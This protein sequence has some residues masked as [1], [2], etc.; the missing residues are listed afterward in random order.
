MRSTTGRANT[1]GHNGH[2]RVRGHNARRRQRTLAAARRHRP[3]ANERSKQRHRRRGN[4][5]RPHPALSATNRSS[6]CNGPARRTRIAV[7]T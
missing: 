4:D 6:S 7:R 1:T 3:S 2:Q 5:R